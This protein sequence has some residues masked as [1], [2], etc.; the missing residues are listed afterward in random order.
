MQRVKAEAERLIDQEPERFYFPRNAGVV[1]QE[2]YDK[3][4]NIRKKSQ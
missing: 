2:E 4:L 1:T 3:I